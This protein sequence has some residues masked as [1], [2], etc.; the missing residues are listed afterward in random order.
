MREQLAPLLG[1]KSVFTA[2]FRRFGWKKFMGQ[3]VAKTLLLVDVK[4]K[5]GKV[6]TDHLWF[7]C[8][9]GFDKLGLEKG[10]QVQFHAKV[11]TYS[12][13]DGYDYHLEYPEHLVKID[14]AQ[15]RLG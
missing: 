10:D 4:D 11:G 15:E 1:A 13:G 5:D 9:R 12:K 7:K 3:Y 14:Q 2:T 8:G 6:V